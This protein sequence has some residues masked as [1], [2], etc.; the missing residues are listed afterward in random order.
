MWNEALKSL[1]TNNNLSQKDVA[2][3]VGVNQTT[4]G[5]Y[6]LGQIE[7]NVATLMKLATYYGV[8]IDYLLG[9]TKYSLQL[10]RE[11]KSLLTKLQDDI[12]HIKRAL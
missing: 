2:S 11:L 3:I 10:N 7:P 1:R 8:S 5:R 9:R 6:E 4:Y 12:E